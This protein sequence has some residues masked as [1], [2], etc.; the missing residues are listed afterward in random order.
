MAAAL[1]HGRTA[2]RYILCGQN[3]TLADLI[4]TTARLVGRPAPRRRLSLGTIRTAASLAAAAARV[5]RLPVAPELLRQAGIYFYY[6]G[7]KA[8]RE[9]GLTSPLPYEPAALAA[10]AWYR[11]HHP[12]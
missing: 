5:L 7:E 1:E 8:R 11:R 9:L 12:R 3:R 4:Q 6:S 2:E 10:A